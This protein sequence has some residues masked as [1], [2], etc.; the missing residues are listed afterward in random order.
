MAVVAMDTL[1]KQR[2]SLKEYINGDT[3]Y[4]NVPEGKW[5]VMF[6]LALKMALL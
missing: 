1:T 2:I 3:L 4:W 5:K 6:L